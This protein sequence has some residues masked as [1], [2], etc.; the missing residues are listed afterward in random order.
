MVFILLGGILS[1]ICFGDFDFGVLL[2][3]LRYECLDVQVF[4]NGLYCSVGFVGIV[5]YG[6]MCVLLMDF[7][8]QVQ[9]VVEFFVVWIVQFI[10]VMVMVIGGFDYVVFFGGIG[11][12]VLVLWVCIVV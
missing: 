7:G 3:L 5:G 11:Y 6:D 4:E 8:L 2:Y 12:C 10:V 9:F 1:F